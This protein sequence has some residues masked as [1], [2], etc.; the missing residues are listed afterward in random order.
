MG[1]LLFFNGRLVPS[2]KSTHGLWLEDT[3]TRLD[4]TQNH[5]IGKQT[6]Y[7]AICCFFYA[8]LAK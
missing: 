2:I 8:A 3:Y 5:V 1:L 4:S 6:R 7:H